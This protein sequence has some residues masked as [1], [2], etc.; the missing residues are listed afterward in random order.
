MLHCFFVFNLRNRNFVCFCLWFLDASS[1]KL[2]LE[3]QNLQYALD[4]E[5]ENEMN[6]C[7]KLQVV[8]LQITSCRVLFWESATLLLN[9][10][11]GSQRADAESELS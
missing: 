8:N 7:R 11:R 2:I 10:R 6:E 1:C 5:G 9:S 4:A 3:E